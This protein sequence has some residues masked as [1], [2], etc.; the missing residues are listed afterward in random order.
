MAQTGTIDL[1]PQTAPARSQAT[2]GIRR[3]NFASVLG[4]TNSQ[5]NVK[6]EPRV[7]VESTRQ[8]QDPEPL[9]QPHDASPLRKSEPETTHAQGEQPAFTA[10]RRDQTNDTKT[11]SPQQ[12]VQSESPPE[13]DIQ[14]VTDDAEQNGDHDLAEQPDET[15]ADPL[16]GNLSA[17]QIAA[18]ASAEKSSLPPVPPPQLQYAA[19]ASDDL[20]PESDEASSD[21]ILPNSPSFTSKQKRLPDN[22]SRPGNIAGTSEQDAVTMADMTLPPP[23]KEASKAIQHETQKTEADS[24]APDPVEKSIRAGA[25]PE[26]IVKTDSGNQSFSMS[27]SQ[28]AMRHQLTPDHHH[29]APHAEPTPIIV[30]PTIP[31]AVKANPVAYRALPIEISLRALDGAKEI[32]VELTP[33]ELGA[34]N[35]RISVDDQSAIQVSITT[36]KPHTLALL[37]H[38]AA[39]I[40][41][42][43]EQAG[44]ST[45]D[46]SLQFSLQSNLS[47]N[48]NSSRDEQRKPPARLV[49]G[50][51]SEEG[52]FDGM[53][54]TRQYIHLNQLDLS[55]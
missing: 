35:I 55:V 18:P 28:H 48:S 50:A 8:L 20:Q 54:P 36:E 43:L 10:N 7:K 52:E 37:Q 24:S 51:E 45:Q 16:S 4:E 3:S 6:V 26:L 14:T 33:K 23:A 34:L 15:E 40:R 30:P 2:K 29:L 13:N 1:A 47:S 25:E 27:E 12:D 32:T 41:H 39:Y 11:P 17:P 53:V 9:K 44:Y 22:G 38:D 49:T 46:N 19:S 31:D 42:S 21:I 5:S